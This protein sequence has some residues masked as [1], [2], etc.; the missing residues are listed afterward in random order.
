[1]IDELKKNIEV[2]IQMLREISTYSRRI[3]LATPYEEKLLKNAILSLKE[4]IRTINRSVPSLVKDISFAQKLPSKPRKTELEN[5][6]FQ[7]SDSSV[8][9]TLQVK[10]RE[11]F[12]ESLSINESLIRRLRKEEKLEGEKTGEFKA[13]RGYLK[14]SNRLFLERAGRLINKGWFRGLSVEISKANIDILFQT[15]IAMMILTTFI[16]V[17]VGAL[18]MVFLLFFNV[19]ASWPI[20]SSFRGNYLIRLSQIFWIPF[21]LPVLVFGFLYIY[22]ASERK[23]IGKRLD[24]ELPFAVI[25]M[26]AIS[27]SGIAPSEIFRIIGGGKEYPYLRKE[28]RK[29]LNQINLYGYDLVT[30]ISNVAKNTSSAKFSELLSGLVTT[31]NSGGN[32]KEFFEKRAETLLTT[33]R[34]EREKATRVAETFMDIY[35]SVVI[36]APMILMLLLIMIAVSGIQVGFSLGVMTFI[37]VSTIALIN[38]AF[39]AFLNVKQPAY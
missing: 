33:Y 16:S 38:I 5:I 31:I 3:E 19:A 25:H 20:I 30:A 9:V 4:S 26:S 34:L 6:G 11:K 1:M 37:I 7:R 14:L 2:E 39:I 24:Q 27:G 17:F 29:I 8:N 28:I 23:T 10:D 21:V 22:P 15:Y 12:L 36:A 35:I 32:L 13:T 18:L